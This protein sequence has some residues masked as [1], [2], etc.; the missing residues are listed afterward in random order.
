MAIFAALVLLPQLALAVVIGTWYATAERHRV[1]ASASAA[2]TAIRSQ[3]DRELEAM[4]AALQALATSPNVEGGNFDALRE[5]ALEL[6]RFRGSAIAV[7]DRSHQQFMNTYAK[8][9]AKLPVSTDPTLVETDR[10]VFE[11]GLPQVSDLYVGAVS[12]KPFVMVDVPLTRDGQILYALNMAIAPEA[13]R[14][15]LAGDSLPGGWMVSLLDGADRVIARTKDHE[16]F[17]GKPAT[18]SFRLAATGSSGFVAGVES[19]NGTSV[20]AAYEQL[21]GSDWRVVVSVPSSVLAAPLWQL[22]VTLLVAALLAAATS[23]L[24]ARFYSDGLDRQVGSVQRMADLVGRDG[25]LSREGGTVVELESIAGAL[26]EADVAIKARDR[27]KDLLLAELNHRV[28]NTLAVLLSVVG[29]TIRAG[30]DVEAIARKAAG[31]IMALSRAHDLLSSAEWSPI[32]LSDLVAR[33]TEQENVSITYVGDDV[34]LRP[35]AVA[36]LAQVLHE[37]AVNERVHTNGRAAAIVVRGGI[38]G[39]DFRLEWKRDVYDGD[40]AGVPSGFGFRLVRLC[41]ERQLFGTVERLEGGTLT[42]VMPLRFLTVDDALAEPFA[43][44]FGV[45]G[46]T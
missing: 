33:T 42:A 40:A 3:L 32:A 39:S 25:P 34:M 10:R 22:T 44:R 23:T 4:K 46:P 17:V 18:E 6:L 9:G 38:E 11:T 35:E 15:A 20:S 19:L 31:R 29:Q 27:H 12:R 7:R 5:Q 28:R 43:A 1:E 45:G 41:L 21:D 13:L 2:A 14:D 30:G 37:L 8:P 16:Q 24:L 26:R 36:P